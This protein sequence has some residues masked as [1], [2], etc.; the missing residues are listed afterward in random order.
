MTTK[1]SIPYTYYLRHKASGMQYYGVKY[2]KK[3]DPEKFWTITGYKTSSKIIRKIIAVEGMDAF[4]AEVRKIFETKEEA[5]DHEQRFLRKVKAPYSHLW[6][7]Q[8]YGTG[9]YLDKFGNRRSIKGVPKTE[10]HKRRISEA[11]MGKPNPRKN[12]EHIDKLAEANKGK[13][14]WNKGKTLSED[15]RRKMSESHKGKPGRPQSE[16]SKRK[17]SEAN[18]GKKRTPEQLAAHIERM[19]GRK[20]SEETKQKMSDAQIG[21]PSKLKG[22]PRSEETK[23]KISMSKMGSKRNVPGSDKKWHEYSQEELKAI[24]DGE[25]QTKPVV[26]RRPKETLDN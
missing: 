6:F 9:P 10:E 4:H 26:K 2:G 8:A 22:V 12:Q 3:S 5:V 16:E 15:V 19:T 24:A 7:N 18:T 13:T 11:K 21:R 20:H 25:I 1:K 23:R 17:I 14:P